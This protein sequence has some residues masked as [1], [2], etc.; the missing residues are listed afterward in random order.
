MKPGLLP[1]V[2]WQVALPGIATAST[3]LIDSRLLASRQSNQFHRQSYWPG[4]GAPVTADDQYRNGN[5]INSGN[6]L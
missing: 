4:H 6:V 1:P 3:A 5:K 2:Y